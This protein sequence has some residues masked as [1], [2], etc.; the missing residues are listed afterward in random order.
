MN[1]ELTETLR[2]AQR[3][4]FFGDRPIEEAVAHS[5]AFVAALDGPAPGVRLVDLGS[6]GGLPGLVLAEALP[7]CSVLLLDRRT[8]RTDFLRRAVTRLG[9]SNVD[10]RA[11]DANDLVSDVRG[12]VCRPFDVVT[13]RGFGPPE[14]TLRTAAALLGEAGMAV[15]SEPPSGDRWDPQLLASLGLRPERRGAV[16]VFRRST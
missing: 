11:G 4:G 14:V 7:D 15:I 2:L 13:A 12:G 9:L 16:S 5:Q 3:L 6:G 8:K 10:V 1:P